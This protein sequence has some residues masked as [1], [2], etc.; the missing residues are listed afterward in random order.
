MNK[1]I[2]SGRLTKDVELR[3]TQD[4]NSLAVG[5]FCIAVNRAYTRDGKKE[6]DFINCVSFG[7][8]AESISKYIK[9]GRGITL[10]GR[11]QTSSYIDNDNCKRYVT[12]I[13]VEN[14][15]FPLE[16]KNGVETE[17]TNGGFTVDESPDLDM[18]F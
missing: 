16:T 13:I 9:K 14:F 8:K 2:L 6:V 7:K 15:E 17:K 11:I 5:R 12:E 4:A 10:D 1:V 18:P 3:Y